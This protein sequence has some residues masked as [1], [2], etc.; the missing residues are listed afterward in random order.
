MAGRSMGIIA[1]EW[2]Q[3]QVQLGPTLRHPLTR[4]F[5]FCTARGLSPEEV[6]PATFET[7]RTSVEHESLRARRNQAFRRT[8]IAWNEALRTVPDW[9]DLEA[10]VP[11]LRSWYVLP[12]S[13]F[14]PSLEADVD[15]MVDDATG[16]DLVHMKARRRIKPQSARQRVEKLRRLISGYV[17]RGGDPSG[18]RTLAD[19]VRLDVV[20]EGLRSHIERRGGKPTRSTDGMIVSAI[21]IAR[22]WVGVCERDLQE[23]ERIRRSLAIPVHETAAETRVLLRKFDDE[24]TLAAL[25]NAPGE[26]IRRFAGRN[27]L[28]CSEAVTAQAA[29][30][31][32]ML[33]DAPLRVHNLAAID[34]DRHLIRIGS[35]RR[36]RVHLHFPAEEVKNARELEL[37]LSPETV[38]LLDYYIEFVRPQL[39]RAPSTFLFPGASAGPKGSGLMSNQIAT[40]VHRHVG[41]R[42]TA[43]K[44]RHLIG[45]LYLKQHPGAHEVV[46]QLLGHRSIETTIRHY[47]SMEQEEAFRLYDSVLDGLR[48]KSASV[49]PRR[50]KAKR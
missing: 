34:L 11:N 22:Q 48:Q 39:V 47:A 7:Y 9:P 49:A 3:L 40:F 30:A 6:T 43:H 29:L 27:R 12:W 41:V 5:S 10:A 17:L 1:P 21:T 23:L 31:V 32:Q 33:L 18:L 35:D 36:M 14:P 2:Q 38:E 44:F 4:F 26:A 42:V 25:L 20:R 50:R 46:R 19:V 45:Y 13:D 15:A 37:P 24:A 28:K 16:M 8:C